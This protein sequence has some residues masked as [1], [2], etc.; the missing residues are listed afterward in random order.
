[1][2]PEALAALQAYTWPGNVREL[3]H[4]VQR[5][6]IVC[7]GAEIR[8]EEIKVEF[9]RGRDEG[10]EEEIVSFEEH[11]RRYIRRVLERTRWKIKGVDGAAALLGINAATLRSRMKR[12]GIGQQRGEISSRG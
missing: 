5:A 6:V 11:E 4:V 8:A 1:L 10:V 9:G 12:L 7:Q 3:E 2:T